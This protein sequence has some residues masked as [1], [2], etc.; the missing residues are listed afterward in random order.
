[1][2]RLDAEG[3]LHFTNRGGIRRKRY[4]DEAAG[5]QVQQLW[6]DIDPINSQAQERTGYPTQ[7][8]L[9]LYE[10][11]IKASSNPGDMVLDPFCGCATTPVAAE[12]EK[13]EWVGIDIWD[14]AYQMVLNRLDS[15][16]FDI[17]DSRHSASGRQVSYVKVDE[18]APLLRTDDIQPA[19]PI[20]HTPM[21]SGQGRRYPRP[22][23]QHAN[24]LADIG[25]FCQGCGADYGFDPRALEVDHLNPHSSGGTDAY[26]NLTLLCGPCNIA[27]SDRITLTE[28]QRQNRQG[29]YLK[30][31]N[32]RNIRHGRGAAPTRRRRR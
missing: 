1:M 25:A 11:I 20:L 13:R 30:E 28:L 8:P 31:G 16:G 2:E 24:L 6:A 4:L 26:D 22:R 29:E 14:Y 19:P 17:E 5:R 27:K 18:Q 3:R 10:R 12:R 15:I 23:T 7:K 21:S 9:A 32:E